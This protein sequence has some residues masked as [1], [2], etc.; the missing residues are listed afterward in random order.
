[1][2][3]INS[4]YNSA[5]MN[6]FADTPESLKISD[7]TLKIVKRYFKLKRFFRMP[8]Q[9]EKNSKKA[10]DRQLRQSNYY[11]FYYSCY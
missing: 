5:I 8:P 9:I 1:M 3:F 10:S 4:Y 11:H 6:I 7:S 2:G